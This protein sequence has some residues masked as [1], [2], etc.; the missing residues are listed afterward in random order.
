V[1]WGGGKL[2]LT[3][4]KVANIHDLFEIFSS[5]ATVAAV[6]LAF[7]GVNAWRKQVRAQSDHELAHRVTVAALKYKEITC[8]AFDDVIFSVTQFHYAVEEVSRDYL[9]A[10]VERFELNLSRNYAA[11]SEFLAVLL[12]ARAAW[13]VGIKDKY[14]E[15][16]GLSEDFFYSIRAFIEWS[17]S[18]HGKTKHRRYSKTLRAQYEEFAE[19]N[20][21]VVNRIKFSHILDELTIAADEELAMRSI[22]GG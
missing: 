7:S 3:F 22:R 10:Y 13:G 17:S 8:S 4:F 9:D 14:L 18:E 1:I 19:K 16:L 2:E 20:W 11:R 12:E 6:F 21:L 15:L 5:I